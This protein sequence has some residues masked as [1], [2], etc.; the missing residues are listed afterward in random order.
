MTLNP[1]NNAFVTGYLKAAGPRV[2]MEHPEARL[3]GGE[4]SDGAPGACVHRY[5]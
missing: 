1:K 5:V 2:R 4:V 3:C